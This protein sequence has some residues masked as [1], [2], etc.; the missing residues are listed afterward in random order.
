MGNKSLVS[1]AIIDYLIVELGTVAVVPDYRLCPAVSVWEGPVTD[2]KACLTWVYH[3]LPAIL[4][5][6]GDGIAI[7]TDRIASVGFSAGGTLALLLVSSTFCPRMFSLS[8]PIH[9]LSLEV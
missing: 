9:V 5:K 3:K 4:A 7:D 6:T 8:R 1:K 2:A